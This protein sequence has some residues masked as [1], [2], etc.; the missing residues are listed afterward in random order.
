LIF[1][2]NACGWKKNIFF[3][4]ENGFNGT[5]E[6]VQVK[7]KVSTYISELETS[8]QAA[9]WAGYAAYK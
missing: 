7:K 8:E 4:F 9:F 2:S 1:F 6:N 5:Y 3:S